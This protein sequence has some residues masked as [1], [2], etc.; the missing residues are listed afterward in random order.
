M[1]SLLKSDQYLLSLSPISAVKEGRIAFQ[2]ILSYILNSVVKKMGLVLIL[3]VGL[4]M[5]GHAVLTPMLMVIILITGDFLVMAL[6]TDSVRPSETPNAWKIGSVTVAGVI[7]G[8]CFLAFCTGIMAVGKYGMGLG[9]DA[10]RTLCVVAVV[11]AGQA[12]LYAVRGRHHCWGLRPTTWMV[13]A[14]VAILA[15]FQR[16]PFVESPWHRCPSRCSRLNL[17]HRSSSA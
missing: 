17:E 14:S 9:L 4:M 15:L 12:T 11:Y 1:G 7:L 6:T 3:A 10:L 5:T 8:T 2:R 13:A 16:W